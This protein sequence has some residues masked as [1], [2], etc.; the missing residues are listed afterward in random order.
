MRAGST[1][2][3]YGTGANTIEF[4]CGN[5]LTIE[6]GAKVL[7]NGAAGNAEAINPHRH[8]QP[9]VNHGEIRSQAGGA[10]FWF[11][12]SRG[13]NTIV[14]GATGII[15]Y[16][17]GAGNIMGVSGTMAIDFTNKGQLLGSLNF[18]NGDD[19]LSDLHRLVDH[20][21]DRR[22]RRQQPA[23]AERHRHRHL[24]PDHHRTSRRW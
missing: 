4:R 21:R 18:A 15:E 22:R 14:N 12:S 17:G 16:K 7:S 3:H 13:S 11:E 10:A 20:R 8:R 2:G 6:Q 5:T 9:I 23:D 24:H 19:T 1:N